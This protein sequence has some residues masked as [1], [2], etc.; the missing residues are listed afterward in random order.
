MRLSKIR[1]ISLTEYKELDGERA[2]DDYLRLS[3]RSLFRCLASS[4]LQ[5]GTG[6]VSSL[7]RREKGSGSHPHVR[8]DERRGADASPCLRL[9][10]TRTWLAGSSGPSAGSAPRRRRD[11]AAAAADAAALML[12]SMGHGCSDPRLIRPKP[13]TPGNCNGPKISALA[14]P[15]HSSDHVGLGYFSADLIGVSASGSP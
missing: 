10:S 6:S 13:P 5:R 8:R 3:S 12:I 9:P 7:L 4:T 11:S 14:H 1:Y 2:S 15:L